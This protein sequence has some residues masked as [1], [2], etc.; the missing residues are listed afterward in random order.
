MAKY[1]D[2]TKTDVYGS[3]STAEL[4]EIRRTLAKRANQRMVRLGK[5][6]S[7]IT[8]EKYD[9]FG[10]VTK[11]KDYLE[12][13]GRTRFTESLTGE[14]KE[15]SAMSRERLQREIVVLQGFLN[16][17][18]SSVAGQRRAEEKRVAT[19]SAHG[20][21]RIARNKEF[22]DFLNSNSYNTLKKFG[23]GNGLVSEQIQDLYQRA[24]D[25]GMSADEIQQAFDEYVAQADR[26]SIKG[27]RDWLDAKALEED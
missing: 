3:I 19:F 6:T 5:A 14:T 21:G 9:E 10:A 2:L 27:L 24:S 15:Y 13:Y 23:G 16:A 7:E 20:L 25:E 22:Y 8:G 1:D 4:R 18:T 12:R 11:V 26:V 17:K